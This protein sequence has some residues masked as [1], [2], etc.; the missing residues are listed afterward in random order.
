MHITHIMY[1]FRIDEMKE[2]NP[3]IGEEV[4]VMYRYINYCMKHASKVRQVLFTI[5][6]QMF[7]QCSLLFT[8]LETVPNIYIY[9]YHWLP[10]EEESRIF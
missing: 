2:M 8:I 9:S 4:S 3:Y 1:I 6:Y 5:C 7:T 10:E